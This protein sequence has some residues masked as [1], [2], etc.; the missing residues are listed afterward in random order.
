VR[1]L[2]P[3]ELAVIC[4]MYASGPSAPEG[5]SLL[6]RLR[7]GGAGIGLDEVQ[8]PDPDRLADLLKERSR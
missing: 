2:W 8:L 3:E 1:A 6:C 4:G 5:T 7:G